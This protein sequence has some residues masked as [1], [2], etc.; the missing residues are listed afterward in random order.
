MRV[1][2]MSV[3]TNVARPDA[4]RQPDLPGVKVTAEEVVDVA[5]QA[6][7]RLQAILMGIL[8]REREFLASNN[9]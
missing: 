4:P 3:V 7:P 6:A 2:A 8:A 1:L 9:R 5:E